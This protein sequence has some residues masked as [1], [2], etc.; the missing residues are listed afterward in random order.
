[1]A[2]FVVGVEQ[3]LKMSL[4]FVVHE[5]YGGAITVALPHDIVDASN[6]RQVPDHQE[7]FLSDKSLT[8]IIFEINQYQHMLSP[9]TSDNSPNAPSDDE[10]AA[11]FHVK[12]V[13]EP[14][15]H[16]SES[17]VQTLAVKLSQPSVSNYPAYQS[18]ATITASEVDRS[19]RSTLPLAWQTDPAQTKH[20]IGVIQL[21][22]RLQRYATDICVRIN[23]PLKE[24]GD[25]QS[26]A[27]QI[28]ANMASEVMK[29]IIESFDIKN[30]DLFGGEA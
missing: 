24:L 1:M 6:L 16:L 9:P 11:A 17:G 7:V 4:Q 26:Q 13:I 2:R 12:D 23:V 8:S 25:A 28:E 14:P 5:L 21:L 20:E 3:T 15:D 22:V 30:F 18:T 27:A 29:R 19:S 10:R